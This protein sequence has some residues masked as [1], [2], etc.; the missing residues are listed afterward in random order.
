MSKNLTEE[1]KRMRKIMGFTYDDNSHDVLSEQYSVDDYLNQQAKLAQDQKLKTYKTKVDLDKFEATAANNLKV[2]DVKTCAEKRGIPIIE[3]KKAAVPQNF[4][5]KPLPGLFYNNFVTLED[6]LRPGALAKIDAAIKKLQDQLTEYKVK[7]EDVT[8]TIN[9]SADANKAKVDPYDKQRDDKSWPDG[10]VD[11][12]YDGQSANN[13]YLAKMRGENLGKY[14]STKISGIKITHKPEVSKNKGPEYIFS[15]FSGKFDKKTYK[16]K[17]THDLKIG[18]SLHG[19]YQSTD[20]WN[21]EHINCTDDPDCGCQLNNKNEFFSHGPGRVLS[22][23]DFVRVGYSFVGHTDLIPE[24]ED[25]NTGGGDEEMRCRRIK[26]INGKIGTLGGDAQTKG[27]TH[28]EKMVAYL[29]SSG[30]FTE[31]E[32]TNIVG[33]TGLLAHAAPENGSDDGNT[34]SKLGTSFGTD[35]EVSTEG[36]KAFLKEF[37]K[38]GPLNIEAAKANGAIVIRYDEKG[39]GV[40]V[41]GGC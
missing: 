4:E 35:M 13:E 12:D 2:T 19:H 9:S 39:N 6:G 28:T 37:G 1:I 23:N 21:E 16:D 14:L 18:W 31:E 17:I 20:E 27:L 29:V 40:V 3:I 36:W 25:V 34:I 15:K 41:W 7:P 11:H 26:G 32:A 38:T 22:I 10:K 8:I 30:Y 33:S 24:R 5:Q